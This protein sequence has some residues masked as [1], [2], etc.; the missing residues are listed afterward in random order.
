M[1]SEA[2]SLVILDCL[3]AG[4]VIGS[5]NNFNILIAELNTR[6]G[7]KAS[8]KL[9]FGYSALRDFRSSLASGDF[10]LVD[11]LNSAGNNTYTSFGYE[12]FTYNNLLST[13]I[14][15][16]SDIFTFYKGKHEITVGTQNYIKK[17]KNGFAPNY[18]GL[19]TLKASQTFITV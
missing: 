12:P 9:Q 17:F 7:N 10:P 11:I 8:N 19:Y 16:L 15:Q 13:D 5:N 18:E 3:L 2:G 4:L 6:L 1:Q 14:Y